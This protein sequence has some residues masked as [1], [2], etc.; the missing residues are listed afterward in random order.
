MAK[1]IFL[2]TGG[3]RYATI[4]QKRATGGLIIESGIGDA[5]EST[6]KW[7]E[8]LLLTSRK[9]PDTTVMHVDPGPGALVRMSIL[10]LDPTA[11]DAILVSHCHP[12]HYTDAEILIEAMTKGSR[13]KQ[14]LVLASKS[15]IEGEGDF[16]P[17]ISRYHRAI[18]ANVVVA[19]P[20]VE[21]KIGAFEVES[22]PVL[23]SDPSS[24][25]FMIRTREGAIAY[26]SDTSYSD[27]MASHYEGAR[28]LVLPVTRPRNARIKFHLSTDDAVKFV[29]RA[30]PELA[31]LNHFGIRIVEEG[32]EKEAE[33]VE[34]S[35]GVRT[36]AAS[37]GLAVILSKDLKI[38]S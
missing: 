29:S 20:G 11:T 38:L 32:V 5:Q 28:V 9:K 23:H 18:A 2:G 17:A 27:E 25:G 33:Y 21:T 6:S 4:F 12:D 26:V 15:V 24:V 22:K 8:D 14:G 3:G 36:I 13:I 34:S 19:K 35:T 7:G 37:D 31:V 1:L 10:G 16:G 30:K